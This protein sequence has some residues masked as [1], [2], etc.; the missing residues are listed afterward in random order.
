MK[1]ILFALFLAAGV[2]AAHAQAPAP[3]PQAAAKDSK[4]APRFK[5]EGGET[6]DFGTLKEGPVAEYTFVFKNVG[7]EPLII[8][9]ASASCG[10]TTPEWPKEPILPNKKGKIVVRYNTQGRVGPF[11]K[12]VFITSNAASE[13]ER[14]ELFIKGTVQA[15]A[16]ATTTPAAGHEG[17]SH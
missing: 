12:T 16:A 15:G 5:F 10:C 3:A 14:Y 17:H 4:T 1:R 9:N 11:N 7:K 6:H 2:T 8:Q 13:K